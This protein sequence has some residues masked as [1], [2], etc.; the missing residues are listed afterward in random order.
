MDFSPAIAEYLEQKIG[1]LDKF[2]N[3]QGSIAPAGSG[4]ETVEAFVELSKTTT[5][6]N[7]GDVYRAE[8][9]LRIPGS[10][11]R[12]EA[13][14]SDMHLAIDR[15]KDDLQR[16]LRRYKE[17]RS[18]KFLKGARRIKRIFRNPF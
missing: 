17:K 16:Q 15:A 14:E 2:I 6:Q 13:T 11:I 12:V 9:Q 3:V 7:K 1:E 18:A 4:R 8:V 5:G 10:S